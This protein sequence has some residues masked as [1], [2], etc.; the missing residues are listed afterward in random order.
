M[1][2]GLQPP[3]SQEVTATWGPQLLGHVRSL[4]AASTCTARAVDQ[5]IDCLQRLIAVASRQGILQNDIKM[6]ESLLMASNAS[7]TSSSQ[8]NSSKKRR[9]DDEHDG[10]G[11][12]SATLPV[13]LVMTAILRIL[14]LKEDIVEFAERALLTTL[15]CDLIR[16]VVHHSRDNQSNPRYHSIC[17]QAELE[18]IQG[19]AKSLLSTLSQTLPNFLRV[20]LQQ[21]RGVDDDLE[22][23]EALTSCLYASAD[24]IAFGGTRL[25][26]S[27]AILS[28]L[29][30]V[31]WDAMACRTVNHTAAA[32]LLAV[33]P[34]A[35]GTE[36][37]TPASQWTKCLINAQSLLWMLLQKAI[38]ISQRIKAADGIETSPLLQNRMDEWSANIQHIESQEDRCGLVLHLSKSLVTLLIELLR[39]GEGNMVLLESS[40]NIPSIL[41][42]VDAL[43]AVPMSAEATYY[44]A[45]KRLRDEPLENAVLS[46]AS[47]ATQLANHM[48]REGQQLLSYL[49]TIV[50]RPS[51][52]P[53]AHRLRQVGYASVLTSCSPT[54]RQVLE[55]SYNIA[56][57]RRWLPH[58]LAARTCAL[59]TLQALMV[60]LGVKTTSERAKTRKRSSTQ[61]MDRVVKVVSGCLLEHIYPHEEES[62]DWGSAEEKAVLITAAADC[63]STILLSGGEFLTMESRQLTDS[64]AAACL[65]NITKLTQV[66]SLHST[67]T[68]ESVL[69][70]G[71]AC[72]ST[73]WPDGAASLLRA[74]VRQAAETV[75]VS[76]DSSLMQ[77]ASS[78]CQLCNTLSNPSIPALYVIT[79]QQEDPPV[80]QELTAKLDQARADAKSHG[81]RREEEEQQRKKAKLEK[82][83]A[84]ALVSTISEQHDLKPVQ[85]TAKPQPN[86]ETVDSRTS[87]PVTSTT[88]E[89]APAEDKR[90]TP[91]SNP[92]KIE[93]KIAPK[94]ESAPTP[95]AGLSLAPKPLPKKDEG[96]DLDEDFP[97]IVDAAPDEEDADD[98]EEA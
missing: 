2:Q 70:L 76:G 73:S 66:A 30:S 38:P 17:I 39:Q 35:G 28:N 74:T 55:P 22:S 69:E 5:A 1:S 14:T 85:P 15:A 92:P 87:K 59:R 36:R 16:A 95:L 11:G 33:L 93:S 25:S 94:P 24:L 40:L 97:M 13:Q 23:R 8:H 47:I 91:Q 86:I 12:L 79:R 34:L 48:Y 98:D 68:F 21:E 31:A 44:G 18:W 71:K 4:D 88:A 19:S 78:A 57:K 96:S 46:P 42:L 81:E 60:S 75:M 90:T 80:A 64:V 65:E 53:Y 10:G 50:G 61:E 20:I 29:E 58:S 72:L 37:A 41:D 77:V 89:G 83:Q 3:L 84:K 63:L 45:K 67:S 6:A 7:T 62:L 32:T 9:S 56:K 26:R 43:L 54:L 52:L 49:V 27:P 51:L 82:K